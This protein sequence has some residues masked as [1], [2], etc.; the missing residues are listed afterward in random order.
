MTNIKIHN[1]LYNKLIVYY[2]LSIMVVIFV[3]TVYRSNKAK[4]EIAKVQTRANVLDKTKELDVAMKKNAE[5]IVKAT[6]N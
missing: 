5:N 1:I 3:N 4:E 6:K 2:Y